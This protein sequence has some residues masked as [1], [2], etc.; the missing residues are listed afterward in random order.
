MAVLFNG[1]GPEPFEPQTFE[2]FLVI[3]DKLWIIWHVDVHCAFIFVVIDPNDEW[4]CIVSLLLLEN[5]G[6]YN[7]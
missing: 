5:R 7:V 6:Y 3:V 1:P 4:P 2:V